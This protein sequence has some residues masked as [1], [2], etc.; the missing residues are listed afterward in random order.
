MRAPG[1][2]LLRV[3]LGG[4]PPR[5]VDALALAAVPGVMVSDDP[6]APPIR[7]RLRCPRGELLLE[8]GGP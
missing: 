2:E 3:E 6:V 8:G 1:V 4:M 5:V 7:A